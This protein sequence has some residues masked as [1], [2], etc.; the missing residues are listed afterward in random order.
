MSSRR[1]LVVAAGADARR[2]ADE[3]RP[4]D[5]VICADAGVDVAVAA[6]VPVAVVVGDLDSASPEALAAVADAGA[7]IER[8]PEAKDDSDLELAL[9]AAVDAGVATVH[10]VLDTGGR[11][12]HQ[13]AN[14]LVLASP[15]WATVAVSATVGDDSLWVVRE[16]LELPLP[17]GA[18]VAVI[19]VGGPAESVRTRGLRYPL[20]GERLE[21]LVARG[22]A[23][24]VVD[25]PATVAVAGGVV[26]VIAQSAQ[27]V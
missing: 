11:L 17:V 18:P 8:H 4:A 7:R 26:L 9:R 19:A 14:L 24:E 10:A 27:A 12:D 23:N 3:A 21:P 6:G 13:L 15:R 16:E 1:A 22:I 20:L 2:L 5:L 25:E